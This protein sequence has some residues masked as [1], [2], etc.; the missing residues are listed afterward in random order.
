MNITLHPS[1]QTLPEAREAKA[2]V[3]SCVHCGLCTATCPTYREVGDERDGPRGRIYLLKQFLEHG[4][5]SNK[6]VL[7]LDRCLTCLSCE[8]HCPSMV[9]YGRL[10]DIG[11]GMLEQHVRRPLRERLVRWGLRRVLPYERRFT[12]LL[13]L[14]QL[15]RPVLP[16]PVKAKVPTRQ[17][18]GSIP[19]EQHERRMLIA[20]ACAQPGARPNTNA[21]AARVLNRLGISLE[22]P[23]GAGCCGALSYHFGAHEEGLQ[24]MRRNIDAWWP[25]IAAGAE[26]IVVTASGCGVMIKEYGSLLNQDPNYAEKAHRVSELTKDLSEILIDEELADLN[27]RQDDLRT[28]VHCPCTLHHGQKL[29]TIIDDILTKMGICLVATKDKHMC[30]GSAGTYSILQPKMSQALLDNKLKALSAENPDRIVTAN[31][32]CELHLATKA[33]VPVQHWIEVLDSLLPS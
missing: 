30:C 24:F 27:I 23:C 10:V 9:N 12:P 4:E 25:Q 5:A 29:P 33:K 6:T 17:S 11:R 15:L 26:A 19:K 14:G 3:R 21:A 22:G 1:F 16:V 20:V 8:T 2:I 18:A 13:R 32:G 31:I 28:A 7:H